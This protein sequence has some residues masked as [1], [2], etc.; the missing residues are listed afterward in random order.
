MEFKLS[1]M[2]DIEEVKKLSD[3]I[4]RSAV[5]MTNSGNS[6]HVASVLSMADIM[7][8][9]YGSYLGVD[10]TNPEWDERDIFI[11]SK[12]HAGAGVY[13]SLAWKG[14][15]SKDVL[16]EHYR[17][18]SVLSGHVSHKNVPGVEFST[19]SL[20]H[21][22]PVAVGYAIAN[23]NNSRKVVCVLGDGECN[24]GSNWEA[25]LI[26]SHHEL[27]DLTVIIDSNNY[28]SIKTT[29]ETLN[30]APMNDKWRSFGWDVYEVDGHNVEELLDSLNKVTKRPKCIIAH[31]IKGNGVDFMENN[32][33]WHYRSPQGKELTSALE[34]LKRY[35]K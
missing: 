31:T 4:R 18:G 2:E 14:F 11:L 30:M 29:G 25:A 12:G 21:G 20:G 10:P 17:N 13:A 32:I 34:S 5:N 23:K 6:S 27:Y 15:F 19:G 24:E 7:G 1:K 16:K 26:A 9:L 28:Q 33:L 8:A 35:E 22:L 3:F